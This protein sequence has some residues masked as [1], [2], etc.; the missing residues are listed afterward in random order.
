MG[1]QQPQSQCEGHI[2]ASLNPQP[3]D[4]FHGFSSSGTQE[5]KEPSERSFEKKTSAISPRGIKR[6][7]LTQPRPSRTF[8]IPSEILLAPFRKPRAQGQ[9]RSG[10]WQS[11]F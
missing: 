6:S 1:P 9:S 7:A 10:K 11:P 2:L 3:V 4:M 5:A 8:Q